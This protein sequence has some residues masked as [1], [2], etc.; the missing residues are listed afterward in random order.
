[1]NNYNH[2]IDWYSEYNAN[3][4]SFIWAS[5]TEY[6]RNVPKKPLIDIITHSTVNC[7][8]EEL[9]L[10][11]TYVDMFLTAQSILHTVSLL[12]TTNSE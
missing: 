6:Q 12:T 4:A 7:L 11:A 5:P 1:M 8:D 2:I 3:N 9:P 10:G